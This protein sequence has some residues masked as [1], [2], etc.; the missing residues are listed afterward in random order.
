VALPEETLKRIRSD[1]DA[2]KAQIPE[3]EEDLKD[4]RKAG[5][6]VSSLTAQLQE[7][8]AQ[9]RKMEMVYGKRPR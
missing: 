5:I 8:K 2:A 3:L 1:I 4:A 7:R 6:D 9:I